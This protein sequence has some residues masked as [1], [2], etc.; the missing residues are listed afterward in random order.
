VQLSK[1]KIFSGTHS[2]T[3]LS[4]GTYWRTRMDQLY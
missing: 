2:L 3:L 1:R 4:E